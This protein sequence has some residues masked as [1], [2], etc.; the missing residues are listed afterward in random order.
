MSLVPL[1]KS[2][3]F[4]VIRYNSRGV[5][6]SSGRSSF[7]G[8]AEGNDLDALLRWSIEKVGNVELFTVVGYSHGSLIA[9][10]QSSDSVLPVPVAHILIS[11]P[12]GPLPFLTLF[13][14]STYASKLR[15]LVESP[16]SRVLVVYGDQDEFTG[17]DRY[18]RW[19][20]ML[21][22]YAHACNVAH[23]LTVAFIPDGSH[24]WRGNRLVEAV[25]SWLERL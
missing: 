4:H 24:F 20:D 6:G 17:Y 14:G 21:Q 3:G 25:G 8:F 1:L 5:G 10:L 18:K 13:R 15:T 12:L 19:S 2:K 9:S 7:T 11:Y 22:S 16:D 23:R